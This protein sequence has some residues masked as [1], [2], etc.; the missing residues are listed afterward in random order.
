MSVS[1]LTSNESDESAIFR[2]IADVKAD[3]LATLKRVVSVISTYAGGALPDNARS[4]VHQHLVTL[5]QRFS[6]ASRRASDEES[7]DLAATNANRALV[8]AQEGLDMMN[9][10]TRVVGDTLDSAEQWCEKLG[11]RRAPEQKPTSEKDFQSPPAEREREV[12]IKME[13]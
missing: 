6:I 2:R 5:P 3:I 4:L 8:L 11:R 12:D 9:Q 13:M 10:V 7:A 1:S